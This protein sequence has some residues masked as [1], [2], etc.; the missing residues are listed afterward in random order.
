MKKFISQPYQ[1]AQN[2][3]WIPAG[4]IAEIVKDKILFIEIEMRQNEFNSKEE[5]HIF[6]VDYY[7]E[8]GYQ[9]GWTS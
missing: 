1:L 5:A 7:T 3:K 8:Q 2:K 9:E 6:F 4:T